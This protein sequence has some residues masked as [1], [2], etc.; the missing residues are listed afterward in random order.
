MKKHIP[1]IAFFVIGLA[2]SFGFDFFILFSCSEYEIGYKENIGW[3]LMFCFVG[4][5]LSNL[6]KKEE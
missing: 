5:I 2:I 4:L 3:S 6:D 1:F